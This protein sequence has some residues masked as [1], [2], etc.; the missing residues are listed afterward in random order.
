LVLRSPPSYF[1]IVMSYEPETS[2]NYSAFCFEKMSTNR[3]F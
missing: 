1:S 2:F 3:Q